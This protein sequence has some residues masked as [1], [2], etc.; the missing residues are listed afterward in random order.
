M[1]QDGKRRPR[2][3]EAL[4]KSYV[5]HDTIR[6]RVRRSFQRDDPVKTRDAD[7][8]NETD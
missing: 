5:P 4:D 2:A 8:A 6:Y 3:L 7:L 1:T